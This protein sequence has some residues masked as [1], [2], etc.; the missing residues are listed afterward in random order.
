MKKE[1]RDVALNPHYFHRPGSQN[2]TDI[3]TLDETN[4]D[5][6]HT[7][8]YKEIPLDENETLIVTYSPKY[9]A[10]QRKIRQE[11]VHRAQKMIDSPG[12]KGRRKNAN[13]P[14]RFIEK[15]AVCDTGEVAKKYVYSLDEEK[16]AEE[17][18]YDGFYAVVTNI[19]GHP[20]D[21]L[22]INQRRW[23][24]E[25]NFRIMK[26]E[27]EA[28]P[29]YLRREDR[30][31][32]HFLTCYI[33]LLVYRLLEKKLGEEYTCSQLL[34]TL[35]HMNVTRLANARNDPQMPITRITMRLMGILNS[36]KCQTRDYINFTIICQYYFFHIILGYKNTANSNVALLTVFLLRGKVRLNPGMWGLTAPPLAVRNGFRCH[37]AAT[38][39]G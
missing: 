31:K 10:Y 9:K 37:C 23:E 33:S 36:Q 19:T 30:I 13:D 14:A 29:V 4:P 8:F 39:S 35:S 16:I 25:E 32:V 3:S 17:A 1:D 2:Y 38:N 27:F 26:S 28:R 7:I 15:T 22:K 12:R 11:Q 5:I 21:I 6:F 18:Q 20:E 34:R 24:I